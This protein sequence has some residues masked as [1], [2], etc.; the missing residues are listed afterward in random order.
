MENGKKWKS[1][2]RNGKGMLGLD[3]GHFSKGKSTT[4]ATFPKKFH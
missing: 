4:W 3:P 2:M 1:K